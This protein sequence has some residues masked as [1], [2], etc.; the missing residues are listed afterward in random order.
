MPLARAL[1]GGRLAM[2]DPASVPAGKYGRAAL[3]RLGAWGSIERK[4]ARAEN[5]RA[6]LAL[7]ERGEAP[8]GIVYAT[9]ARASAKVRVVGLFP[10]NSHP[11]IIYPIAALRGS[12]NPEAEAFRRFLLSRDGKLFFA[13]RGFAVR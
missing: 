8:F 10:A 5:V 1:G 9:D 11:P 2:A 7:V 13:R 4:I 12:T 6:A 3:V